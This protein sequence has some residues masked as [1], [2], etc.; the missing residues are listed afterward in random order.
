MQEHNEQ[1]GGSEVNENT[2]VIFRTLIENKLIEGSVRGDNGSQKAFYSR[3]SPMILGLC[4]RYSSGEKDA[5]SMCVFVFR[6]LFREIKHIPKDCE[7]Q[8]WVA[9][10][11]IWGAVK[12]LHQDKHTF[13]IAKTTRYEENKPVYGEIDENSLTAESRRQ[14]YLAALQSLTP[15]YRIL[16]NLTYIDEIPY[17]DLLNELQMAAETYKAEL[18]QAKFQFKKQ[19][20]TCNYEYQRSKGEY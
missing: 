14:I 20:N 3:F 7:L 9:N 5:L 12:Y 15:S 19:L 6:E 1:T 17:N 11:A 18:E 8:K 16:Y 13:F 10:R 2:P 4:Y